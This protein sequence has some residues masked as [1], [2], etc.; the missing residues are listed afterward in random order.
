MRRRLARIPQWIDRLWPWGPIALVGLALLI[1]LNS[2]AKQ[3][4]KS[5]TDV[6]ADVVH[7]FG[8]AVEDKRGEDACALLTPAA[9]SQLVE[10]VP[11]VI[12][13]VAVCC[14]ITVL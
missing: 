14:F 11:N 7:K 9:Q 13:Q 10:Q 2:I 6:I 3:P 5:D 4:P 8:K 12:S 1:G